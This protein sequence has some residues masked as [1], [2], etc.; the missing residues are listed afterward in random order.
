MRHGP[1]F[2]VLCAAAFNASAQ[3]PTPPMPT[4]PNAIVLNAPQQPAAVAEQWVTIGEKNHIVRNVTTSTLTPYLPD[5]SAAT[6]AAVIVA[7]GGGFILV[8]METEGYQVAQ[9]LADHG[10]AAFVLKYRVNPT[11]PD[12][13]VFIKQL[14]TLLSTGAGP[15]SKDDDSVPQASVQDARAAVKLVR[16]R[17]AEWHVDTARIGFMGFSSGADLTIAI[18]LDHDPALRPNFIAPICGSLAAQNVPADAPPLFFALAANDPYYG[19]ANFDLINSWRA[20]NRPVE[21][22][23]YE[24]GGHGLGNIHQGTS[25]DLWIEEFYTWMKDR[26]ELKAAN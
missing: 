17:A 8:S 19:K 10:I 16:S 13:R 15:N 12:P 9:W 5:P 3:I 2:A 7:P 4:D 24:K 26:G 20:A 22:H 25:S 11:D 14:A 6:G 1:V 18:G 23:L 21:F